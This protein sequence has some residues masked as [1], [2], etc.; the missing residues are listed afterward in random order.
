MD[1]ALETIN[2]AI[3]PVLCHT[4]EDIRM[5]RRAQYMKPSTAATAH[6]IYAKDHRSVCF[7]G[8]FVTT[9]T[10]AQWHRPSLAR[11][12][13]L[14]RQLRLEVNRLVERLRDDGRV[15]QS[16]E[17]HL[18]LVLPSAPAAAA[19]AATSTS[20]LDHGS[21]GAPHPLHRLL[22]TD[23]DARTLADMFLCSC[24]TVVASSPALH[25]SSLKE[26]PNTQPLIQSTLA[27]QDVPVLDPDHAASSSS[28]A[29]TS[30]MSVTLKVAIAHG[31][32]CPRCWKVCTDM[33]DH[34]IVRDSP[35]DE[36]HQDGTAADPA[37]GKYKIALC[38]RCAHACRARRSSMG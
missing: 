1:I 6:D 17:C 7:D 19:A 11:D 16:L 38:H 3:A 5:H 36:L 18:S 29:A 31:S 26:D 34:D 14:L 24:V 25:A 28:T 15:K 10:T 23:I 37:N 27:I 33:I 13:L 20:G 32:K 2:T 35:P 22:T 12:W 21:H 4:A 9:R 8:W 30:V